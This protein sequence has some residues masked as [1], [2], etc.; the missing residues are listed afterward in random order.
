VG[1]VGD[2]MDLVDG[3]VI[4]SPIE[5]CHVHG[6]AEYPLSMDDEGRQVGETSIEDVR[7]TKV[8]PL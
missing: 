5:G 7:A 1:S 4:P 3:V 6:E 2:G 8:H